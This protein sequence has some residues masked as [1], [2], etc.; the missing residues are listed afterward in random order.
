MLKIAFTFGLIAVPAFGE[1]STSDLRAAVLAGNIDGVEALFKQARADSPDHQRD[2]FDVMSSSDPKVIAFVRDWVAARPKSAYAQA[3]IARTLLEAS[4]DLRGI[5]PP[6]YTWPV[7]L[8]R[9]K[10]MSIEASEHAWLAYSIDPTLV[11]ASDPIIALAKVI[12]GKK[13]G[14][15]VAA[16]VM[17]V[18]P[19]THTLELAL[20]EAW[21]QW[22]GSMDAMWELCDR[23]APRVKDRPDY[24][25]EVCMTEALFDSRNEEYAWDWLLAAAPPSNAKFPVKD[26]AR[27]AIEAFR[28]R[29]VSGQKLIEDYLNDPSVTD[30]DTAW[31][32]DS[33]YANIQR[34]PPI[35]AKVF[36]R[37]MAVAKAELDSDPYDPDKLRTLA[38]VADHYV[39]LDERPAPEDARSL[40][41][42]SLVMAPFDA[43]TWENLANTFGQADVEAD[44]S[45]GEDF[46]INSVVYSN[47]RAD[48]VGRLLDWQVQ[49]LETLKVGRGLKWGGPITAQALDQPLETAICNAVRTGAI[50]DDLCPDGRFCQNGRDMAAEIATRAAVAKDLGICK[51]ELSAWF[52]SSL[53]YTEVPIEREPSPFEQ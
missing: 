33:V 14:N 7:A 12:R 19:N 20:I 5:W 8:A 42:T 43:D 40:L 41:L 2:L 48:Y 6:A 49:R 39:Q 10:K 28:R 38:G 29:D 18:A 17:T 26:R 13:S 25:A 22:G 16:E 1:V 24:S 37:K 32:Y 50:Y 46:R 35:E 23:Y 52:T 4:N 36:A 15:E 51:A 45:E 27:V 34:L 53:Y 47:H 44:V 9:S 11:P 31:K 3:A 21:P 30:I